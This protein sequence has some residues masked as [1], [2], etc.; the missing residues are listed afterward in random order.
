MTAHRNISFPD[1]DGRALT[2]TSPV[3]Q[4]TTVATLTR[5]PSQPSLYSRIPIFLARVAEGPIAVSIA[6]FS[7]KSGPVGTSHPLTLAFFHAAGHIGP[8]FG[9]ATVRSSTS[10]GNA[11]VRPP[12]LVS[13]LRLIPGTTRTEVFLGL[14]FHNCRGLRANILIF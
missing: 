6:T 14:I 1:E 11:A 7:L 9:A 2:T 13:A 10:Q 12:I 3:S 8:G 5:G 4:L